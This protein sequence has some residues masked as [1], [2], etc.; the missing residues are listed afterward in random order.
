M[1]HATP[2]GVRLEIHAQPNAKVAGIVGVH[3]DRLKVALR[4]APQD[5]EANRELIDLLKSVLG[6]ARTAIR[7]TRGAASRTK[8]VEIEGLTTKQLRDQLKKSAGI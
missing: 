6:V 7:L 8:T 4:A 2:N 3:G 5:G 1:I